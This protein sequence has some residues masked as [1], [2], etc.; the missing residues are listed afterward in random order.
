MQNLIKL[1]FFLIV[2]FH[3][4]VNLQAQNIGILDLFQIVNKNNWESVNTL[5]TNKGWE[6]YDSKAGDDLNY[7]TVTWTFEKN[8]YNEKAQGWL[9]LYTYTG[10]PNKVSYQF[11]NKANYNSL[12][13]SLSNGGFKY[14][15]TDIKDDEVISKY[16]NPYFI[17]FLSYIQMKESEDS[18]YENS[19][20]TSYLI[21]VIKKAGVYDDENGLK[22]T[23]Y[24]NGSIESEYTLKDSKFIGLAKVYWENGNIKLESNFLNG[25]KNGISKEYDENGIITGEF[26]LK[27]GKLNGQYKVWENGKLKLIGNCINDIKS[28]NFLE[29]NEYGQVIKEYSLKD[30]IYDGKYIE[31]RYNDNKLR[32]KISGSFIKGERNGVWETT[33]MS[34]GKS[35]I[36]FHKTYL[37][38]SLEGDYKDVSGDSIIFCKYSNNEINGDYKV[39]T[40]LSSM[41]TGEITGDTSNAVMIVDGRYLNGKKTGHWKYYSVTTVMIKEGDYFSDKMTGEWKYYYDNIS[42]DSKTT[43]FSKQLFLVQTYENGL[44]HGR[45]RQ[46]STFTRQ[47]SLCDTIKYKN[48]NPLD[49]CYEMVFKKMNISCFFKN[50]LL[51]GPYE[52]RD[53]DTGKLIEKGNY[54]EGEQDG[55]WIETINDDDRKYIIQLN[56]K[57]G[58]AE[59]KIL[60]KD[61]LNK[62]FRAGV[63]SNGERIGNW[64]DYFSDGISIMND[65]NYQNGLLTGE[66]K[67]YREDET[68]DKISEYEQGELKKLSIYDSLGSNIIRTYEILSSRFGSFKCRRT[69]YGEIIVSQVYNLTKEG[70]E[71]IYG[72]YFDNYFYMNLQNENVVYADGEYKAYN[73]NNIQLIEGNYYKDKKIGKWIYFYNEIHVKKEQE[74]INN[75]GQLE[76]FYDTNKNTLFS[77]KFIIKNTNGEKICDFKIDNGLRDGKSKYYDSKGETIKTEKYEKGILIMD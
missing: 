66:Y 6:F 39:F 43:P 61:S 74:F 12:K 25:L 54:F 72:N 63:F 23:Y 50:G 38:G 19:T 32:L 30:D 51:H 13:N 35:D 22:K 77:G 27:E 10:F 44:K 26:T 62:V 29:Y 53:E 55:D 60:Y 16:I 11:R 31:N 47:P 73:R 68:I 34:E 52:E 17:V 59:G 41:L 42:I 14:I 33:E 28:G 1:K 15:D 2:L 3:F 75:I 36:L 40:N 8:K 48:S 21:T 71:K 49:T 5:L 65:Y 57:K 37:N 64:I 20:H 7:S 67:S 69:E 45:A 24:N 56:Y 76:Y 9:N 4:S 46:F 18:Y 58:K 70:N